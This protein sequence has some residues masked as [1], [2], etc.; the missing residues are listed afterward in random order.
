MKLLYLAPEFPTNYWNFLKCLKLSG[1]KVVAFGQA[2]FYHLPEDVRQSIDWY[3][4]VNLENWDEVVHKVKNIGDFDLVESHDEHW[5]R[6]EAF[7]NKT[8]NKEGINDEFI[9]HWKKKSLMKAK[10]KEINIPFAKG[11]LIANSEEGLSLAKKLNYPVII[12]P[13]EGVGAGGA[14][15]IRNEEQLKNIISKNEHINFIMEEFIDEPIIT[16]DGLT[17]WNG[18]IVFDNSLKYTAGILEF[19]NGRD[20]SFYIDRYINDN[21]R[22]LG[23]KMVEAFNIRKKFFHFEFFVKDKQLIPIEVNCRPPGGP[24]IDMMNYSVNKNLYNMYARMIIGNK[25]RLDR[26]KKYYCGYVG[27]RNAGYI[28]SHEN[29]VEKFEKK[30]I[31]AS[32]NEALFQEAMGKFRY[33]FRTESEEEMSE[34]MTYI[35]EKKY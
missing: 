33:I 25:L 34:I 16:Y 11:G 22:K 32:E 14:Y 2:D 27:R 31:E 20:P 1:I 6:L 17:D 23:K 30:L 9:N 29:I 15:K 7:I 19:V 10:F 24:I 12:K 18:D 4:R 28:F 5:L 3:E 35:L 8:F 13:D 26:D 21:L